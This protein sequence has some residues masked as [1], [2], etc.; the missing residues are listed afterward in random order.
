MKAEVTI[1]I[2]LKMRS[3]TEVVTGK[4]V[5]VNQHI[6]VCSNVHPE[7]RPFL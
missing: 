5:T 3:R 6:S 1:F 4:S 7:R 2:S